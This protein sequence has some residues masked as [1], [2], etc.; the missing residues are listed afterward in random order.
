[1]PFVQPR[2]CEVIESLQVFP[3]VGMIAG[4][5]LQL[6]A[7]DR[8]VDLFCMAQDRKAVLAPCRYQRGRVDVGEPPEGVVTDACGA[9]CCK[10]MVRDRHRA[11]PLAS[12]LKFLQVS[13]NVR[14]A[15]DPQLEQLREL[16]GPEHLVRHA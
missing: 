5:H 6:R 7:S 11:D 1:M 9:L 4:K 16:C 2:G 8:T 13:R 15:P 12:I 14:R 10:G 3:M